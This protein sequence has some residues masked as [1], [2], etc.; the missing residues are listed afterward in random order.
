[1]HEEDGMPGEFHPGGEGWKPV[2]MGQVS[3][4]L[5]P[6]H[7]EPPEATEDELTLAALTDPADVSRQEAGTHPTVWRVLILILI[8]VA[9]LSMVFIYAR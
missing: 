7:P 2:V 3:G 9:A 6:P 5:V 1:M 8:A 4:D